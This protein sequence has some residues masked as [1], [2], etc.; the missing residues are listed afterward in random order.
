MSPDRT[1]PV[2]AEIARL[3]GLDLAGLRRRWRVVLGRA[4]PEH[5]SRAL[6]ERILAYRIQAQ[7]FGDLDRAAARLLDGLARSGA[8]RTDIPLPELRPVKP[9]TLLVREWQGA[10]Q[11]VMAL[12]QG[13]A[14]NGATYAS[15]SEVARAITGTNWNG[16]RF[17]GLRQSGRHKCSETRPGA[18][19]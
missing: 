2:E 5:L 8:K 11:R 12:D 6:L 10:L 19:R 15:L 18:A 1:S 3:R 17:F 16:P 9:G 14:W 4:A 13:F 7:A